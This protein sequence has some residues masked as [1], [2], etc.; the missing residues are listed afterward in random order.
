MIGSALRTF[1]DEIRLHQQGGCSAASG[2]PFLPVLATPAAESD[3][4]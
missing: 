1:A 3:W 2:E 4:R